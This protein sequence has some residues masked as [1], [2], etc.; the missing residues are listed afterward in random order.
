VDCDD[1][2]GD[3]GSPSTKHVATSKGTYAFVLAWAMAGLK[4]DLSSLAIKDESA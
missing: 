3:G 4:G 1:G 2:G